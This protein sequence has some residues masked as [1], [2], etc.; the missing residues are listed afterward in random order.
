ME[1][2]AT[3][4]RGVV[5]VEVT[6]SP[7]RDSSG[8]IIAGIEIVRDIT[9]RKKAEEESKRNFDLQS[10]FNEL[11]R[12]SMEELSLQDILQQALD[13]IVSVSWLSLEAKGCIFLVEDEPDMLILRAS[14]GLPVHLLEKCTRLPFGRCMCGKAALA[15]SIQY[16]DCIDDRHDISYAG[17]EPHGHYCVPFSSAGKVSGVMNLYIKMG[18]PRDERECS[19]LKAYANVL[20]GI[21]QRKR[22]EE[23]RGMLILKL[24]EAFETVTRSQKEWMGTF[25]SI[26]DLIFISDVNYTIIRANR[27]FAEYVQMTPRQVIYKKCYGL[28]NMSELRYSACPHAASLREQRMVQGEFIDQARGRTFIM[29]ASPY[30]SQDG[31]LV[32]S[33]ISC[34][35]VT[36]EKEQEMRL[37]MS[38]RLATL[39]QMASGIA[40]EINNPL[41]AIAGCTEGLLKTGGAGTFRARTVQKLSEDHRGGDFAV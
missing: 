10:A 6:A 37:I 29:T 26:T 22:A 13:I 39:G 28:F 30:F 12:I 23:E 38:E 20:A 17:M 41:A 16:A 2:S 7:V 21:V 11:L 4:D 14:K 18:H 36:E 15:Q 9:Q 33:I 35:D 31:D 19:F 27:A 34:K 1:R 32:G 24:Q 8:K 3:T 25:D 5:Y 40:H